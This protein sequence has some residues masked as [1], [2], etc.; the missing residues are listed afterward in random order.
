MPGASFFTDHKYKTVCVPV[1]DCGL[2]NEH[3][4]EERGS[5]GAFLNVFYRYE[6][7]EKVRCSIPGSL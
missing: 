5:G 4:D 7:N 6:L 3:S 1:E 2:R